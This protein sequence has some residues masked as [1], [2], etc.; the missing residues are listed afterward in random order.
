MLYTT[1]AICN[2]AGVRAAITSTSLEVAAFT[3]ISY[4]KHF[5][6]YKSPNAIVGS[7]GTNT[8]ELTSSPMAL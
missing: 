6:S 3:N 4:G 8:Q 7:F 2:S 1:Y 5:I